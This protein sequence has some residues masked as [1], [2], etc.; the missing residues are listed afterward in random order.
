MLFAQR[1]TNFEFAVTEDRRDRSYRREFSVHTGCITKTAAEA[2]WHALETD[3]TSLG[4][5]F[6]MLYEDVLRM[7]DKLLSTTTHLGY[8]LAC[9]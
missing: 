2:K 5:P 7:G 4:I 6:E 8:Q 1:V 3:I 9:T